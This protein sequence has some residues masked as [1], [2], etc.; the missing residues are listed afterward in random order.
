M[1]PQL[2]EGQADC[3]TAQELLASGA[4]ARDDLVQRCLLDTDLDTM[5]DSTLVLRYELRGFK[6]PSRCFVLGFAQ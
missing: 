3:A 4:Y 1:R 5:T 2:F 6:S